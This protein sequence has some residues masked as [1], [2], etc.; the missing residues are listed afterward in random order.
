MSHNA[1]I[2]G[3]S[4]SISAGKSLINGTGYKISAGKTL[5]NGTSKNID[6]ALPLKWRWNDNLSF[7]FTQDSQT[8]DIE[9][10]SPIIL[11]FNTDIPYDERVE[12]SYGDLYRVQFERLYKNTTGN[13]FSCMCYLNHSNMST[14]VVYSFEGYGYPNTWTYSNGSGRNIQFPYLDN[15]WFINYLKAN[16]TP[17]YD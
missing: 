5:I 7:P 3:A 11:D 4:H 13:H 10:T 2:N 1:L 12:Y 15:E 14:P 6:F 8:I 16:A 17:I 9:F